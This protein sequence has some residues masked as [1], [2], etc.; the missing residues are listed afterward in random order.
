[1]PS[2]IKAQVQNPPASAAAG[3]TLAEAREGLWGYRFSRQSANVLQADTVGPVSAF[4]G[5]VVQPGLVVSSDISTQDAMGND[6]LTTGATVASSASTT[7]AVYWC[8][9]GDFAGGFGFS[10]AAP[11]IVDGLP[12]LNSAGDGLNCLFLGWIRTSAA[13][14]LVDTVQDRL[15]VNYWNRRRT[16]LELCPNYTNDNAQTTYTRNS[17]TWTTLTA[18]A[19]SSQVSFI[20]NGEDA[21]EAVG[22]F[23]M[24]GLP[25]AVT[26]VGVGL[27]TTQPAGTGLIPANAT[28]ATVTVPIR[29]TPSSG[30]LQTVYLLMAN[31]TATCTFVADLARLGAAADPIATCLRGSI[32]A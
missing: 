6:A 19:A 25:A 23:V 16:T 26:P 2:A 20:G 30:A 28:N 29:W 9:A 12:L 22:T 18:A 15:V 17:A 7:F 3:V 27:S 21:A 31:N 14:A 1:M 5:N 13:G 10:T 4:N 8:A 32:W 24:T 11:V